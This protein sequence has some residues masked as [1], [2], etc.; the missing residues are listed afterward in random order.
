MVRRLPL[1]VA[2]VKDESV[3]SHLL[4]MALE[5]KTDGR[6]LLCAL[7][8][9]PASRHDSG[10][11]LQLQM[12]Q[13]EVASYAFACG[14]DETA[15]ASMLLTR[16]D[17][18]AFSIERVGQRVVADRFGRH[19][20]R[21]EWL[22]LADSH[23]CPACLAERC[24]A[25]RIQWKLPWSVACVRH[26]R[27]LLD[28]C[29]GCQRRP[30]L[31]PVADGRMSAST[32]SGPAWLRR[33]TN[34]NLSA[35]AR[36]RA[37]IRT[38]TSPLRCA[39]ELDDARRTR[40]ASEATL[41]AQATI[42]A[43][44][45]GEG[46]AHGTGQLVPLEFFSGLRSICATLLAAGDEEVLAAAGGASP[47]TALRDYYERRERA[48]REAGHD[49]VLW[50]SWSPAPREVA[51][52]EALVPLATNAIVSG[53]GETRSLFAPVV[54]R[55]TRLHERGLRADHVPRRF[56]FPGWLADEYSVLIEPKQATAR[57]GFSRR[58]PGA[59]ER[60][61]PASAIPQLVWER[62]Y[63][64]YFQG[65]VPGW[66]PRH[67]R[68]FVSL[69]LLRVGACSSWRAAAQVLGMRDEGM[70]AIHSNR[71]LSRLAG[72]GQ[73][74]ARVHGLASLLAWQ[75]SLT[76]YAWR[77]ENFGQLTGESRAIRSIAE[78]LSLDIGE[79]PREMQ[80][81]AAHVWATAT[82]GD[83]RLSPALQP[84]AE[85][86]SKPD[87]RRVP[88]RSAPYDQFVARHVS[89]RRRLFRRSLEERVLGTRLEDPWLRRL[90]DQLARCEPQVAS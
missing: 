72:G 1:A 87:G 4:R 70:S 56:A 42:D 18:V 13:S 12:S 22:Y 37:M 71:L 39:F 90:P 35:A 24:G 68:R 82:S 5:L 7:G 20:A 10:V 48:R 51:L 19:V 32:A 74:V 17:Q 62:V 26:G 80:L 85:L 69:A 45:E 11:D 47:P 88:L 84:V 3:A 16:F 64:R 14:L 55:L 54:E 65:L 21:H 15:V 76:S 31:V 6:A 38:R 58:G 27:L 49:R 50:Q 44:L 59:G 9:A 66:Q 8:I 30:G 34:E 29:P 61:F 46:V 23:F 28:N 36:C 86:R 60:M 41:E 63:E 67:G 81:L 25:W 78:D 79:R 53:A 33:A 83:W 2:P 40:S 89:R 52:L 43:A 77:R 57:L 75:R 73:F